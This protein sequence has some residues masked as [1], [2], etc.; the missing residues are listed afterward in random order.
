MHGVGVGMLEAVWVKHEGVYLEVGIKTPNPP[1][2]PYSVETHILPTC[3]RYP[4]TDND[5]D[6]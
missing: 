3:S 5:K 2:S 6:M 4:C 1:P